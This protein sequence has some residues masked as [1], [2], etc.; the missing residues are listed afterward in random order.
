L[1]LP[2]PAA[3]LVER[4]DSAGSIFLGDWSAQSFGDYATGTNH[5]LP[6]GGVARARGGLSTADF[7][8]CVS[9][10]EVTRAG[11]ACL[12]P[13]AKE[14]ARAEGLLAHARAVEVRE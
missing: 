5:V 7:V 9:V 12:A 11:L 13:V 2:G 4:F 8:K 14:F 3:K 10:Q 6:T 1:S